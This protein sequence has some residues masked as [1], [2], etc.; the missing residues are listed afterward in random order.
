MYFV[1]RATAVAS[2]RHEGLMLPGPS[3]RTGI[4]PAAERSLASHKATSGVGCTSVQSSNDFGNVG[5]GQDIPTKASRVVGRSWRGSRSGRCG[6]NGVRWNGQKSSRP[7][8][9]TGRRLPCQRRTAV[10]HRTIALPLLYRDGWTLVAGNPP[11]G[12]ESR[13]DVEFCSPGWACAHFGMVTNFGDYLDWS[14]YDQINDKF[15]F[16]GF[17]ETPK[18]YRS[19]YR[20]SPGRL[21]KRRRRWKNWPA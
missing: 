10:A 5:D 13:A 15:C 1:R 19:A 4:S 20:P 8:G 18:F 2:N 11:C 12:L 21:M 7:N 14:L 6:W 17:P 16:V 9:L 3:T